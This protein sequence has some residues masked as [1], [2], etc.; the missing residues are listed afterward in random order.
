[1]A[2]C[3]PSPCAMW[4]DSGFLTPASKQWDKVPNS[5]KWFF[6]LVPACDN[7]LQYLSTN[8]RL[9]RCNQKKPSC[10]TVHIL[11]WIIYRMREVGNKQAFLKWSYSSCRLFLAEVL[12]GDPGVAEKSKYFFLEKPNRFLFRA[13][14]GFQLGKLLAVTAN[15]SPAHKISL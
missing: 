13:L 2:N 10:F 7:Y 8:I 14:L 11:A 1:M 9:E 6:F 5:S 15:Q 12:A 3:I 4:S